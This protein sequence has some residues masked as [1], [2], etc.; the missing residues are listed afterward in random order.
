VRDSGRI[1]GTPMTES[2]APVA[3]AQFSVAPDHPALPGHFP[4]DPILPGVALL[5]RVLRLLEEREGMAVPIALSNVKFLAPLRPG[6]SCSIEIEDC[7]PGRFRFQCRVGPRV[8]AR[9]DID[10]AARE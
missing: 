10:R 8:V 2:S 4:G 6:D 7:G 3:R 5:Q 1:F 9:G